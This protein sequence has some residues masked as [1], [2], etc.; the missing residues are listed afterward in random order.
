MPSSDFTSRCETAVACVRLVDVHHRRK[1]QFGIDDLVALRCWFQTG[2]HERLA[3]R[4]VLMHHDRA[5]L[6]ADDRRDFI[7]DTDGHIPPS[8]RPRAHAAA[9]PRLGVFV[10]PIVRGPRHRAE[11]VRD[12]VNSLIENGETRCATSVNRQTIKHPPASLI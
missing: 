12:Q 1:V 11:T 9:R 10:E 2:E 3:D 4:D 8:F 5:G 6:R 7:A